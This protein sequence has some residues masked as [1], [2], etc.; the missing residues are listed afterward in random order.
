MNA[1]RNHTMGST[2]PQSDRETWAK[3]PRVNAR[4][5]ATTTYTNGVD[6]SGWQTLNAS[7]WA[8]MY[9]SGIRFAY[10]K[11]TEGTD[12]ASEE[13][14]A[15]YTDSYNAGMSHGAYHFATPNTSSGSAQANYFVNNGG[16]WSADGRTLPPM[17]DIEYN[18]Y[19]GTGGTCYGL[20][21]SAMVSWILDFSNTVAQRTGRLPV[22]YST[23]D[24]WT[25]CTGNS[26][27][28]AANPLFIARYVSSPSSGPGTLPAGWSN[29][30]FWQWSSSSGTVLDLNGKNVDTDVFNGP[31]V[32]LE[33][34]ARGASLV[35]GT[36][37]SAVYLLSGGQKHHILNYSDY[38]VFA[39]RLGTVTQVDPSVISSMPTG[40]DATRYV[41]DPSAGVLYLLQDDGTKHRFPTAALVASYGYVFSSYTDLDTAQLAAFTTGAEV[42][43]FF[44]IEDAPQTYLIDGT[45]K[46]YLP[47]PRAYFAAGGAPVMQMSGSGANQLSTGP[48]YLAPGFPMTEADTS[49][50][51]LATDDHTV[52]YLPSFDLTQDLFGNSGFDT[53]PNGS[54]ANLTVTS[55]SLTAA[56]TCAGTTY[57]ASGGQAV[58]VSG[59]DIGGLTPTSLPPASCGLLPKSL[60]ST[61]APLFVE[62][63]GTGDV[64]QLS[65]NSLRHVVDYS[66]LLTLNGYR[67]LTIMSWRPGT[68][69]LVPIGIPVLA[70]GDAV[71]FTGLPEVYEYKSGQL[72]HILAYQTLLNL[73]GGALPHIE[74]VSPSLKGQFTFGADV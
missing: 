7:S 27:A 42:G 71:Q 34:F 1:A 8:S 72:H 55:G 15:Q 63:K 59:S 3:A 32:S 41:H 50:V 45:T 33:S 24:W 13:F 12:Y 29:Y 67:G 30:T 65:A 51:Y 20:S 74:K 53:V 16:G 22:I 64:Y 4:M 39:S 2:I 10:V 26:P 69:A 57:V 58:Q 54:L 40:S 48:V 37:D 31:G 18:P 19:P 9:A 14:P 21:Q 46:R 35:Q 61:A 60:A 38:V 47:S 6:V 44:R 66:T 11:A 23:T 25:T 49:K 17:L 73:G 70:D 43:N 62:I 36:G 68:A 52:I 5:L 56:V 28:L